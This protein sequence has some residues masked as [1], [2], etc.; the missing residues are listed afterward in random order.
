MDVR[1]C[2]QQES[3]PRGKTASWEVLQAFVL[4][5]LKSAPG[6]SFFLLTTT[7]HG[8]RH[9]GEVNSADKSRVVVSLD[10][11]RLGGKRR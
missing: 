10:R 3:L 9:V 2:E 1:F 11:E 4:R 8:S 5:A 7:Y 6:E